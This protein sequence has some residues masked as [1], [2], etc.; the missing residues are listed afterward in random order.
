MILDLRR[1]VTNNHISN[2]TIFPLLIAI[3]SVSKQPKSKIQCTFCLFGTRAWMKLYNVEFFGRIWPQH[4]HDSMHQSINISFKKL[5]VKS[6][7]NC[8]FHEENI[9]YF[10]CFLLPI[11]QW[12]KHPI[13]HFR[14]INQSESSIIC[15]YLY[16]DLWSTN[17]VNLH[18]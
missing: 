7:V 17:C 1:L 6:Y 10:V 12:R 15:T 3:C 14:S 8:L 13:M 9:R 18:W 4:F 5:Y 16:I 2:C 11:F